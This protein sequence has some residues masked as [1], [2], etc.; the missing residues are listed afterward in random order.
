MTGTRAPVAERLTRRLEVRESGCIEWT[1]ATDRFGYGVI[2]RGARGKGTTRTHIL[3]WKIA[4]G[5]VPDGLCVLHHCDNPPCCET[6]PTEGYPDGHLF[7]GTK[8]DNNAD[9]AAKGRAFNG[10]A[11]RTHCSQGHV[12]DEA[13][14]YV[15]P[16]GR[17]YKECSRT[18][19]REYQTR[20]RLA[21][22]AVA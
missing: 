12:Y 10:F 14:T 2:G 20:L 19:S 22:K 3:A 11:G 16:K 9:K 18:R 6:E 1:G 21:R 15:Y 4:N 17:Q 5:P 8:A 7:L 13:N